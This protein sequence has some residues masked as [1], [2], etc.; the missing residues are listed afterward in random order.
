MAYDYETISVR[1][2]GHVAEI[3]LDRPA[4]L[5]AF[6]HAMHIEAKEAFLEV[7]ENRDVRAIVF[8]GNGQHFSA[9]GDFGLIL[10]DREDH[11]TRQKMRGEGKKLLAAIAGCP[12]PVVT[13]LQGQ[14][15][16][17]GATVAL[18]SDAIVAARN[19]KISDPHV[20]IGLAAGDGGAVMWPLHT[21][22]LRAK[23]YLLTGDR[24]TAQ[25]AYEMGLVTDLVET[26]EEVLDA[27]RAIARRIAGLPPRAVQLTKEV[28]N[29]IFRMRLEELFDNG[30][31]A[32][33]ETFVSEDLV[34]AI[35][36]FR[37]KREPVYKGL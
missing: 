32:E 25:Q 10:R 15:V 29:Q 4:A 26:P 19:A 18:C 22:L 17:L 36:A 21:G 24:L 35:S 11:A 1:I 8:G 7:R 3:L 2:E 23:R 27:A 9:G 37:E 12:I 34:E 13:A 5:N 20:V 31:A 30:M 28:L 16:G 6:D 33:M 14:A